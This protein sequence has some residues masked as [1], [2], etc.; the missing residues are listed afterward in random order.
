MEAAHAS[1]V[2]AEGIDNE[3]F[4]QP[5][6]RLADELRSED[7]QVRTD[8][9]RRVSTI[10]LALGQERTRTELIPFLESARR[11]AAS[12][13]TRVDSLDE[14]D[15]VLLVMAE[16]L[17]G[18]VQFVGG[19]GHAHLLLK[20][21]EG[22]AGA[23]ETVVRD[24]A[25]DS[26]GK[27]L[28]QVSVAVIS[29]QVLPLIKRMASAEWFPRKSSAAH[30][31]GLVAGRVSGTDEQGELR[32][33]MAGLSND[34]TTIVRKA[35]LN[36]L[37]RL[38]K[39]TKDTGALAEDIFPLLSKLSADSQDAVRLLSVAPLVAFGESLK[40]VPE[41]TVHLLHPLF[42]ALTS[43]RSWRIRYMLAKHFAQLLVVLHAEGDLH[44]IKAFAALLKDAEPEV[45]SA[46]AA[47]L[48]HVARVIAP[49]EVRAFLMPCL[50]IV[51]TDP[52]AHVKAAFAACLNDLSPVIGANA[53]VEHVLPL[54][55]KLLGDE[56][57]E[58]RLKVVTN[59]ERTVQ[60][61]GID[62]L[63]DVLLPAISRLSQDPQWRVRETI[64]GLVPALARLLGHARYDTKLAEMGLSWLDDSVY[65][66]RRSAARCHALLIKAFGTQWA[67]DS[68]LIDKLLQL[69][70]HSNYL[71]R[72]GC[73][74]LVSDLVGCVPL[75]YVTVG[76]LL[77]VLE[78]LRSD[79]V[80]NVKVTLAK[81]VQAC[82]P[83]LLADRPDL[84]S[85]T[86]LP[87]LQQLAIDA[88]PDVQFFAQRALN[89]VPAL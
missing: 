16:E 59:F 4:V 53:T 70:T 81:A 55:I 69:A 8:A 62:L 38:I 72:Q 39:A 34:D 17:G 11:A 63:Y 1:P 22:L 46:A 80:A 79:P 78:G 10:A 44:P 43:D 21:L 35:V 14:E 7:T 18:F 48:V 40:E 57:S 37:A 74:H 6:A 77:P 64:I 51:V 73:L 83:V 75:D 12:C 31:I 41:M 56:A 29:E 86:C 45:R 13:V 19:P 27:V 65:A 66:V 2:G 30:I 58:V 67:L 68:G 49:E 54:I 36:N 24:A 84:L 26:L 50:P 32:R 60:V 89:L 3:D 47:E 42:H 71:R 9:M 15:E 88:D 5:V 85:D 87:I 28:P 33:L 20:P 82:V 25:I 76:F 61:I 23:D 52:S